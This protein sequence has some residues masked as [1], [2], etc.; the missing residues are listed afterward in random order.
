MADHQKIKDVL[1]EVQ[2]K[3][4]LKDF[5]N[6][7][8]A[9][10]KYVFSLLDKSRLEW[11]SQNYLMV[12]KRYNSFT[13][14]L[15]RPNKADDEN[16]KG[17]GYFLH[18]EGKGIAID[19]GFDFIRNLSEVGL[20]IGNIDAVMLTHGHND[21]Y[22]D[23]D[24]I[25]SL[26]YEYNDLNQKN[27]SGMDSVKNKDYVAALYHFKKASEIDSSNETARKGIEVCLHHI[28]KMLPL[29]PRIAQYE[30]DLEKEYAGIK[31]RPPEQRF[32]KIDLFLGRSGQ[33][34]VDSLITLNLE[35][36]EN[37]YTLNPE[38]PMTFPEYNFE[39]SF[40]RGKH[41]D[42][43]SKSHCIGILFDLFKNQESAIKI[44]LTSDTGYYYAL[45]DIN[46]IRMREKLSESF[47]NCKILI[48]HIGSMKER[49]FA[50]LREKDWQQDES[51][52]TYLYQKHLGILG[53]AKLVSELDNSILKLVV[54]SEY[55]EEMK[56]ERRK[57]KNNRS[58]KFLQRI[59]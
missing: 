25:L 47:K 50:W 20:K 5:F 23:L 28:K 33:K 7:K 27:F 57:K 31:D 41:Q 48:A 40:I 43:Y 54:V 3:I 44:G 58:I 34:T 52:K 17:G 38:R 32:K 13:P 10:D 56:E 37:L 59:R 8:E 46:T 42:F 21:H 51:L 15:P 11:E 19:P 39:L 14:A 2:N 45:E 29:P 9:F 1:E 36:V 22:I 49:E 6:N 53:L 55:G 18:W 30:K 16:A 12:L 26:L 4:N 35:Q 24:P